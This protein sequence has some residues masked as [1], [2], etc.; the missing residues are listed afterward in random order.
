MFASFTLGR[1]LVVVAS[2]GTAFI[3]QSVVLARIGLPGATPDLLLVVTL[4]L[5]MAAGPLPG[6][7][8][9]FGSG[10]LIDLAPPA[11]G[12]LGLTAAILAVAG[13]AAGHVE[14]PPGRPTLATFFTVGGLGSAA[15]LALAIL[16]ILVGSAG[17]IWSAV[18]FLLVTQFLYCGL[19]AVAI[20]SPLGA[21]YRSAGEEGRYA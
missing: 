16:G 7:I 9:G 13:F 1:L 17:V 20:A 11:S 15:V 6:T 12:S 5:A 8:I 19:L 10:L 2:L 4:V 18:P 14:I 3:L 21:L